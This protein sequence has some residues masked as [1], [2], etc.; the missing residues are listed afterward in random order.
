MNT[1]AE[2]ISQELKSDVI[3]LAHFKINTKMKGHPERT[4]G[5]EADYDVRLGIRRFWA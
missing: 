1:S 3:N 5:D 4:F 2:G